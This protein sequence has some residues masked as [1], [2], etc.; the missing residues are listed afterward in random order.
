[1]IENMN[2]LR[3]P[4]R[5][6]YVTMKASDLRVTR[7]SYRKKRSTVN[8]VVGLTYQRALATYHITER[9]YS[10]DAGA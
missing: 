10:S 3:R 6:I 7:L 4:I 2:Y 5:L 1:M 8:L 9:H